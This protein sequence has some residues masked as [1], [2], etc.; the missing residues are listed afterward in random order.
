MLS[1]IILIFALCLIW[2]YSNYQVALGVFFVFVAC[3]IDINNIIRGNY[4]KKIRD[5]KERSV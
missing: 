1:N 2:K 5:K 3:V 4:V